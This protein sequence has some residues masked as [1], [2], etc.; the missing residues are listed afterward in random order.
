MCL[1]KWSKKLEA[2]KYQHA[3]KVD[4]APFTQRLNLVLDAYRPEIETLFPQMEFGDEVWAADKSPGSSLSVH[5]AY[6]V[7][8]YAPDIC[9][10]EDLGKL[11]PITI[12]PGDGV[13]K[14]QVERIESFEALRA[15]STPAVLAPG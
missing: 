14:P 10:F 4:T 1:R 2:S 3:S 8:P 13:I 9:P 15:L 7:R 5:F 12:L 6:L 11:Q